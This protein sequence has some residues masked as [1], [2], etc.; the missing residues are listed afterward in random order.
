[1]IPLA[2]VLTPNIPE[3]QDHYRLT[4]ET[5]DDM[6]KAARRDVRYGAKNVLVKGGHL[7]GDARISSLT[8]HS[9]TATAQ[10]H[11][12]KKYPRHRLHLFVGHCGQSGKR[13]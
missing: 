8:A 4:I 7:G 9:F 5:A 11:R 1:M 13:L 6:K 12:H 10:T 2:Y 3:A